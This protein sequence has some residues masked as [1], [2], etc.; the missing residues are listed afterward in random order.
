ML[1]K[2]VLF[3]VLIVAIVGAG[4]YVSV[5]VTPG[6]SSSSTTVS[7]TCTTS[8]STSS[9]STTTTSTQT[10]TSETGTFTYSPSAPLRI[11]SV[12]A[13]T[14]PGSG[15]DYVTF[16]VAYTNVGSSDVY[17]ISGCGSSLVATV[18]PGSTGL[19]QVSGGPVCLCAEAPM[20]LPPGANRTSVTPGCWSSI[21][22]VVAHPGTVQV[23][24]TL[25]W[26]PTQSGQQDS[27]TI[28]AYFTFA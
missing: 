20:A 8:G 12:N 28:T 18:P 27:T 13:S 26:G 22:Y 1:P 10:S 23:D 7:S 9:A 21:K 3:A 15:G 5:T 24:L 16:A 4:A 6:P 11:D 19:K 17:T 14:Y 25:Y 2:G